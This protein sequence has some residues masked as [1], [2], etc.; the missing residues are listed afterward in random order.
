MNETVVESIEKIKSRLKRPAVVFEIG[1]FR[2]PDDLLAPWF[3]KVTVAARDERWPTLSDGTPMWAL[4]Q[5]NL[6]ALDYVP[7]ALK[8]VAFLT[9]FFGPKH[10]QQ[11]DPNGTNWL[12]RT[13]ASLEE[14]APLEQ[15]KT[16]SHLKPFPMRPGEPV[17][18]YPV[19]DGG[20]IP[21]DISDLILQLEDEGKIEDYHDLIELHGG[22][23]IG[24][25]PCFIQPGTSV[26]ESFE[27]VLQIDS[28]EKGNLMW[29]HD[30]G[31]AYFFRDPRTNE[32]RM[33]WD[34][35]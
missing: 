28:T 19:W 1:G 27:F 32:W 21:E 20:D 13:Y 30:S 6:S 29:G 26:G 24:G 23:K 22:F 5:V 7:E 2:P 31:C 8:D 16:S 25:H 35:Y 34:C 17:E 11:E 10:P 4:G 18:D 12:I 33:T 15:K 3:G 14:L 9:I